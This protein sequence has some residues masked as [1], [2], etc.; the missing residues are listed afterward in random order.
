MP[1]ISIIIPT[2]N[3]EKYIKDCL[4]SV[5]RQ[6]FR[7]FEVIVSDDCSTDRT[8]EIV[9]NYAQR[10]GQI[11]LIRRSTNSGGGGIPRNAFITHATGKYIVFLDSDDMLVQNALQILFDAAEKFQSD[12]VSAE[13]YFRFKEDDF[14][15]VTRNI[16]VKIYSQIP[17]D[18]L[19]KVQT[20]EPN[21]IADRFRKYFNYELTGFVWNKI[22]RRDFLLENRIEFHDIPMR[23]DSLFDLECISSAKNYVRIPQI[24]NLYRVRRESISHHPDPK[25][26]LRKWISDLLRLLEE[27]NKF[28]NR[29]EFFQRN[30]QLK[31]DIL[32]DFAQSTLQ[33]ISKLYRK[34]DLREIESIFR[35][36]FCKY[37]S[38]TFVFQMFNIV[39]TYRSEI[40]M[41]LESKES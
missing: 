38:A 39:Q 9:E 16:N 23:H 10:F 12:M 19:V 5:F 29:H 34:I 21:D 22:Y 24:V 11:Q 7:D 32:D 27:T 41:L 40:S 6:T 20:L 26:L 31:Y 2:Y 4:D 17:S 35:E 15:P 18:K 37:P 25:K 1:A 3:V 28:L 14:D 36:E 8:V 30:P 13:S 33:Q